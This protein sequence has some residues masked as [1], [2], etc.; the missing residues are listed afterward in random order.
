MA[1]DVMFLINL[2]MLFLLMVGLG[3]AVDFDRF[4]SHFSKPQGLLVG[5]FC[6]FF[7]MPP[8]AYSI[9]FLIE[10]VDICRVALILVACCPG[11]A[12]SNILCFVFRA[13]LD[14]S[15]A[16][17]TASSFCAIFM[18]PLNILV[19][20]KATGLSNDVDLDYLGIALSA[21]LVVLG[22]GLGVSIK[23]WASH[24]E[25]TGA[26]VCK[27][28]GRLGAL[29]GLGV[30]V[31]GAITNGQSDTPTWQAGGGIY[32]AVALQVMF[33]ISLGLGLA[34]F[35]GLRGA[36][37]VA[38]S[39][40]TAVQNSV[41]ALSI[42]SI[43]FDK[44]QAADAAV[45]PLCYMFFST[46]TNVAWGIVSWKLFGL[47]DLSQKATICEMFA[48]YRENTTAAVADVNKG[49]GDNTHPLDISDA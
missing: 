26:V 37:C 28:V 23:N 32:G 39:I 34:Y 10:L 46:W 35:A 38:V 30:V 14:L 1:I 29:D 8:I 11:G 27:V 45:V 4:K 2:G 12:L 24:H 17:T 7:L 42:I 48:L 9:S 43:S 36:S 6:Q 18:M 15:V 31:S 21:M 20:V 3:L 49:V 25:E 19:Y 16:M 44:E 41:L 22:L 13:D 47:T 33:G 5:V 40:E